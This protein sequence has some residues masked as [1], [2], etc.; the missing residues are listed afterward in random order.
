MR[1]ITQVHHLPVNIYPVATVL[2][3]PSFALCF[4]SLPALV[5][6]WTNLH[7]NLELGSFISP[8]Y[9]CHLESRL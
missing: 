8:F 9:V 2:F 1:K 6:V 3:A 7:S 5:L 4:Q